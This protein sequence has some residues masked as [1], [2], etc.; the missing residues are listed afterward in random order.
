MSDVLFRECVCVCV[1]CVC[2]I[3]K[4]VV[5]RP[6]YHCQSVSDIITHGWQLLEELSGIAVTMAE[7]KEFALEASMMHAQ[8]QVSTRIIIKNVV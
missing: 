5:A 1:V 2:D 7:R 6:S 4:L 3:R 8:Q